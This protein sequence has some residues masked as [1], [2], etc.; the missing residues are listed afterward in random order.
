MSPID[1]I[2]TLSLLQLGYG[3]L[4]SSPLSQDKVSLLLSHLPS[5]IAMN[6]LGNQDQA[7]LLQILVT[8]SLLEPSSLS[9]EASA[10]KAF[11]DRASEIARTNSQWQTNRNK[12]DLHFQERV[13]SVLRDEFPGQF[14]TEVSSGF[15][16]FDVYFPREK[17]VVEI[18]GATHY[19]QLSEMILP[20]Y[21]LKQRLLEALGDLN[22]IDIDFHSFLDANKAV[23]AEE[24]VDFV[25]RSLQLA[26]EN[27]RPIEARNVFLSKLLHV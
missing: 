11:T 6:N 14:E 5:L 19:Y 10:L 2:S 16:A 21:R 25:R 12:Y 24:I 9:L 26:A 7:M 4:S 3:Q 20:K 17:L 22:L 23:K 27:P 1:V 18:N 8:L 15:Y 13:L